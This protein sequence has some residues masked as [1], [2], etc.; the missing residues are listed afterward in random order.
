MFPVE[1]SYFSFQEKTIFIPLR[2]VYPEC[3]ALI[4]PHP[5]MHPVRCLR[6]DGCPANMN[7][8]EHLVQRVNYLF[9]EVFPKAEMMIAYF[10]YDDRPKSIRGAIFYKDLREPELKT[11]NP[12]GF[13]KFQREGTVG[14]WT[15][16][17]EYKHF[18]SN[19]AIVPVER[20]VR[21]R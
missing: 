6:E 12:F 20:L 3:F 13:R 16:T 7:C 19:R 10:K 15:L 11:L 8:M 17:T 1:L 5:Q 18:G 2:Y 4:A 21:E 9:G 14:T